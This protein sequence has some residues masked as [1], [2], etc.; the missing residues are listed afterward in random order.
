MMPNRMRRLL[1]LVLPF[2]LV[3]TTMPQP[4]FARA[5]QQPPTASVAGTVTN[6][7]GQPLANAM[8]QLRNVA[9]PSQILGTAMTNAAGEYTFTGLMPGTYIVEAINDKSELAGA[10]AP[11]V[12]GA[13]AA[14]T[15][16]NII[17]P[18]AGAAVGGGSNLLAYL[19][20][21]IGAAGVAG[22]TRRGI[23]VSPS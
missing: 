5:A 18:V 1:S 4:V 15:G 10:S 14:V 16:V 21:L 9:D 3:A 23:T 7:N 22:L 2:C 13:D 6:S 8:V 11:T 20:A 12:V 17:V 19:I